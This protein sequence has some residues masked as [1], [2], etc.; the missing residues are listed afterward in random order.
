MSQGP[1][2]APGIAGLEG[3]PGLKGDKGQAG[4]KGSQGNSGAKG[5]TG[6]QGVAGDSGPQVSFHDSELCLLSGDQSETHIRRVLLEQLR[7]KIAIFM[8][9]FVLFDEWTTGAAGQRGS[10]GSKGGDW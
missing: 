10:G 8:T 2:G 1:P 3:K 6:K 9:I 7:D 5:E 4:E